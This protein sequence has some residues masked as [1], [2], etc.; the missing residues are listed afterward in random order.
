M[1]ESL[2]A[3]DPVLQELFSFSKHVLVSRPESH[4]ISDHLV[5][6]PSKHLHHVCSPFLQLLYSLL[7]DYR[8]HILDLKFVVCLVLGYS[9]VQILFHL[10]IGDVKLFVDVTQLFIDYLKLMRI[11]ILEAL[12]DTH[13]RLIETFSAFR[14]NLLRRHSS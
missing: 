3:E 5:V 2:F 4:E 6:R 10:G 11:Q 14:K 1:R 13:D 8:F 7:L 9:L 12:Y